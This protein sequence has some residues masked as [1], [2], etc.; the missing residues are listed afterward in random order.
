VKIL[1]IV[2]SLTLATTSVMA[3]A[4]EVKAIRRDAT[5]I[6]QSYAQSNQTPSSPDRESCSQEN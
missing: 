6:Y 2:M 1:V 3:H 4:P 5:H